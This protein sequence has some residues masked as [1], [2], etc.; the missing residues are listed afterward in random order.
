MRTDLLLALA[1]LAGVALGGGCKPAAS[2][3][4]TP[5]LPRVRVVTAE[6]S[7]IARTLRLTGVFTAPP[8]RDVKLGP[9]V[10]GRLTSLHVAE[11]DRVRAGQVLGEV[12]TGPASDELQQAEATERE[13][14]AAVQA[15]EARRARTDVLVERG[16]AAR[17]DAE[18]E[19]SAEAAAQAAAQRARAAVELARRKV[20]RSELTAPFDGVVAAVFIRQG[21]A[22]DGTGQPV[23]ELAATDPLE[24]RAWASPSQAATLH[25]GL[26][27]SLSPEGSEPPSGEVS[28]VSPTLD[29]QSGNVLVRLRFPN[30]QGALRLGALGHAWVLTGQEERALR[31]PTSALLPQE[32]GGVALSLV[33]EGKVHPL[34]VELLSEEGTRAVVRAALDGGESIISE[35]GYSLPEGSTVEV[36]R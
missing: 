23:V 29:A 18:Q 35:G 8:G 17:Q 4:K 30:P 22:V 11:G 24:L 1:V 16:V 13:A 25:T 7:P 20:R 34:P 31:V 2:E 36:L 33:Q 28:M 21:E 19:H 15:A 3:E 32:D 14:T 6:P 5:I 9:L 10:P 26:R 12:E 27:A